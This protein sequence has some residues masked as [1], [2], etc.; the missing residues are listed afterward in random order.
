MRQKWLIAFLASYYCVIRLK[1]LS[2]RWRTIRSVTVTFYNCHAKN[3]LWTHYS[4]RVWCCKIPYFFAFLC[5]L[6]MHASTVISAS[7]ICHTCAICH[8]CTQFQYP[9]VLA[10][11]LY[12]PSQKPW[13][14]LFWY[15]QR[16]YSV[17]CK[18]FCFLIQ[19][20]FE[21]QGFSVSGKVLRAKNVG[22]RH[23][24]ATIS[25]E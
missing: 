19:P 14:L 13:N 16:E 9:V 21:V 8:M 12:G 24:Y 6:L 25:C 2:F 15:K 20:S 10:S 5:N 4:S 22:F 23:S 18:F 3:E 1:S 17:Y 11:W 7:S